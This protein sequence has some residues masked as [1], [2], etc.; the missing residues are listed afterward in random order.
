MGAPGAVQILHRRTSDDDRRTRE[1]EYRERYLTPWPAAERGFVDEVIDPAE[2]RRALA[3]GLR[4]LFTKREVL[5]RRKH[6]AGP[7]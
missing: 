3:A 4:A 6:D 5:R 7:L 1:E 2:T